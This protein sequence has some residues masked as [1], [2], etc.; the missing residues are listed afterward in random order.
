MEEKVYLPKK[1][2]AKKKEI[3]ISIAIVI[4]ITIIILII[5]SVIKTAKYKKT[6]EYKLLQLG[7]NEAEVNI[8]LEDKRIDLDYILTLEYNENLTK[9]LS[10]KYYINNNLETYLSYKKEHAEASLT[11]TVAIINVKAQNKWYENSVKTDVSKDLLMLVNKFHNLDDTFEPSDLKVIKNWYAYGENQKL[12]EEAYNSFISMYNDASKSDLKLII[13]SAYRPYSEQDEVYNE[14]LSWYGQEYTDD[15]AARPGYSEHQTGL[16]IDIMAPGY[17]AKDFDTSDEYIW[18]VDNAHKYGYILR[19]PK[20]KEYL[21][22][23][24]Y[25]SWHFRYVGLD[26]AKYI[27]ENNIT[28]DEYY[29]YYIEGKNEK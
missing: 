26:I 6:Y 16:A 2:K 4:A 25:E 1:R 21:T 17:N 19:Y 3:A 15:L 13:N 8:L 10:E 9:L 7:Y 24:A 14:Y 5:N 27:Y 11:D 12:R 28:Y 29:A 23:Y 18:L 22:G 20:E